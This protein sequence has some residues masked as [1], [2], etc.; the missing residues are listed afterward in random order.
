MTYRSSLVSFTSL[1]AG[2]EAVLQLEMTVAGLAVVKMTSLG[3]CF[4]AIIA[5]SPWGSIDK[6]APTARFSLDRER[7]MLRTEPAISRPEI[8]PIALTGILLTPS[9][10]NKN[11]D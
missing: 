1:G 8:L 6:G 3:T 2:L 7:L 9:S 4:S 5:P 10:C 11:V